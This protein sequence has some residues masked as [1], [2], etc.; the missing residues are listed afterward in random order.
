MSAYG[1]IMALQWQSNTVVCNVI[2]GSAA[3]MLGAMIFGLFWEPSGSL[4]NHQNVCSEGMSHDCQASLIDTCP[5]M[6]DPLNM[7]LHV[8]CQVCSRD[9][10]S[11]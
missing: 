2:V 4:E 7:H 1:E 3:N 11:N 10:L 9:S 8:E 6:T 5:Y